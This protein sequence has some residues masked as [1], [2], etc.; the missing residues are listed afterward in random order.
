MIR[1]QSE[2]WFDI[3]IS[4]AYSLNVY[5]LSYVISSTRVLERLFFAFSRNFLILRTEERLEKKP[6]PEELESQ[7][8]G[9]GC[10]AVDSRGSSRPRERNSNGSTS[11]MLLLK[12]MVMK[13]ENLL[14]DLA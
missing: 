1:I 10:S 14:R 9:F 13:P 12:H 11:A 3:D 6:V 4:S 2:L 7:E 8:M 5:N